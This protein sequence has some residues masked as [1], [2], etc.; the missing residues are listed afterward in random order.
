MERAM[1]VSLD[2][3]RTQCLNSGKEIWSISFFQCHDPVSSMVSSHALKHIPIEVT[4]GQLCSCW[5]LAIK[6]QTKQVQVMC[7]PQPIKQPNLNL[8]PAKACHV[9]R[10]IRVCLLAWSGEDCFVGDHEGGDM[11]GE[12]MDLL[13][14]VEE[15][16]T[17]APSGNKHDGVD[18]DVDKDV[19]ID[20]LDSCFDGVTNFCRCNAAYLVAFQDDVNCP[21]V[22]AARDVVD[23][24]DSGDPKVKWV[25]D[26][27][28]TLPHSDGV[29]NSTVFLKVEGDGDFV[30]TVEVRISMGEFFVAMPE[31]DIPDHY[32]LGVLWFA[33]HLGVFTGVHGKEESIAKQMGEVHLNMG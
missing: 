10:A 27:V 3:R 15:E 8:G 11:F 5:G 13:T 17:K 14:G 26:R 2:R 18:G 20:G 25:Q 1:L 9:D 16:G 6:M 19:V 12:F 7:Q 28:T 22:F 21:G 31:A 29:V 33:S 4:L 24:L 23:A 30:G 32:D